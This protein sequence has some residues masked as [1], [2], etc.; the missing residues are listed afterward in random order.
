MNIFTPPQKYG[1]FHNQFEHWILRNIKAECDW[2]DHQMRGQLPEKIY[3]WAHSGIPYAM[4][5]AQEYLQREGFLLERHPHKLC[6]RHGNN[7]LACMDLNSKFPI[8]QHF[9]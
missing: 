6:I 8:H 3:R 7:I 4:R 2:I 1:V 9:I 5:K